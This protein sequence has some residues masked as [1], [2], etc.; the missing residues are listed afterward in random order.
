MNTIQISFKS[1]EIVENGYKDIEVDAKN[2]LSAQLIYPKSGVPAIETVKKLSL[3]DGDTYDFTKGTFND[4]IIYEG[5]IEGDSE[6]EIRLT[7]KHEVVKMNK[8]IN[9]LI[10][11]GIV[12]GIGV[13]T[14][15]IGAA[16]ITAAAKELVEGI[17]SIINKEEDKVE[18]KV[19][20][21]GKGSRLFNRYV[22]DGDFIIP[23]IIEEETKFT[24]IISRDGKEIRQTK[25]LR[26]GLTNATVILDIKR[27]R[28]TPVA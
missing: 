21:I 20:V 23:L 1:I 15:G 10:G 16:V 13:A 26:K 25:T 18:E 27:I 2:F 12:A 19:I 7:A 28:K 9:D 6:I 24:Q 3:T 11:T 17:F 8:L 4:K 5:V 14:G 22:P